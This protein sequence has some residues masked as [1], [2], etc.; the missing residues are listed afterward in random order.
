MPI[1]ICVN[2]GYLGKLSI[3]PEELTITKQEEITYVISLTTDEIKPDLDLE[4][5]IESEYVQTGDFDYIF[6]RRDVQT[7]SIK[8]NENG[9]TFKF[10]SK[11]DVLRFKLSP[12]NFYNPYKASLLVDAVVSGYGNATALLAVD[13]EFEIV[14][15]DNVSDYPPELEI[16][17]E[18]L[19]PVAVDLSEEKDIRKIKQNENFLISNEY[20][21]YA[22]EYE[23][24]QTQEPNLLNINKNY[25]SID[26]RQYYS[27]KNFY[28]AASRVILQSSKYSK[29]LYPKIDKQKFLFPMY[30]E[31]K[32]EADIV[33]TQLVSF[34]EKLG[35]LDYFCYFYIFHSKKKIKIDALKNLIKTVNVN[36]PDLQILDKYI[37]DL[38]SIKSYKSRSFQKTILLKVLEKQFETLP[39]TYKD[40]V[41]MYKVEKLKDN[42]VINEQYFINKF[43]NQDIIYF[44]SQLKYDTDYEYKIS[45]IE[46]LVDG[47]IRNIPMKDYE[48][49]I[50]IID[51]P[52][53]PPDVSYIPYKGV[54]NELLINFNASSGRYSDY[55]IIIKDSDKTVFNKILDNSLF[56]RTKQNYNKIEF[57]TDDAYGTFELYRLDVPPRS[58]EDFKAAFSLETSFTS[59][60]DSIQ[61]NKKY[62]YISRVKDI[63]GNL[64]NPTKPIEIEIVNDGGTIFLIK[65][66]YSFGEEKKAL[67]KDIKN[68]LQLKLSKQQLQINTELTYDNNPKAE[69]AKQVNLVLG[70]KDIS[71]WNKQFLMR[72][73]SKAT[74]K[75]IDIKFKFVHSTSR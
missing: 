7:F 52:P 58:Y 27:S 17:P 61:P 50:K 43:E 55:P 73:T 53:L 26:I 18:Q 28:K 75:K 38:S 31:I 56:S 66:E 5:R 23:E 41:L 63:H 40:Q 29:Q 4:F 11:G 15:A 71:A 21:Y 39:S 2:P 65:R 10:A 13:P 49:K 24:T 45:R 16:S 48:T 68:I 20:N 37:G 47:T 74:G 46:V 64:S 69:S 59:L 67:S 8:E 70:N 3:A 42:I 60:V 62:Y 19:E 12:R 36:D 44:D 57:E 72:V 54:D 1:N 32:F 6:D 14:Q 34:L 30:M 9:F 51:S 25:S 35:M 33:K 22:K